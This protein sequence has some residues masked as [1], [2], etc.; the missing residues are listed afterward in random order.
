[1][2][3]LLFVH[4]LSPLHAGTG[5]DVG[6]VDLPIAR[7]KATGFPYLPGSSIKGVLRDAAE[8]TPGFNVVDLFGPP[9]EDGHKHAGALL[10]G[11]ANLLLLPVRSIVGTF[12]WTTSPWL[13]QRFA[14]DAREAGGA[15]LTVPTVASIDKAL[16][17]KET[18]IVSGERVVFEDLDFAAAKSDEADK[19]AEW[20]GQRL[21]PDGAPDA[22]AWRA[23]FKRKLCILHDDAMAFFSEHGTD[24]VTRIAVDP[25]LKTVKPGA[26]WT[27]E[28]LP[29]ETV[30]VSL[31]A[32]QAN[33]KVSD[34]DAA[35]ERLQ[36]L[37][38]RALQ[39]G[40]DATTGRGRCRLV[41]SGGSR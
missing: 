14:R 27:E 31:L 3:S 15:K 6:A 9:R 25:T 2:P 8:R 20:L 17:A 41:L 24:I 39:L 28:S 7:D 16:V 12:A 1:M 37:L 40:G 4:A 36:P 26:L 23:L 19:L 29:T 33:G 11:D 30:L 35:V 32:G 13:L 5:H 38:E 34:G 21:F 18:T 22:P 10:V